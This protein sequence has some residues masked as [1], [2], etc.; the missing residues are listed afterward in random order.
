MS[1]DPIG[2]SM[3]AGMA[4]SAVFNAAMAGSL[5]YTEK[6]NHVKQISD[7]IQPIAGWTKNIQHKFNQLDMGIE[8][9]LDDL[10]QKLTV[11]K[12]ALQNE[13]ARQTKLLRREEIIGT[14]LCSMVSL[15]LMI[16][17]LSRQL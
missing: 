14:V 7:S 1:G 10:R 6:C 17:L 2:I 12:S 15:L 3:C 8:S 11:V 16:R 5:D 4:I 13:K 9:E